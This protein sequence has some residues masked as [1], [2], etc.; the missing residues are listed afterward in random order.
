MEECDLQL[1]RYVSTH[2]GVTLRDA[3]RALGLSS[4]DAQST[5]DRLEHDKLVRVERRRVRTVRIMAEANRYI[6]KFPEEELR[7]SLL[8]KDRKPDDIRNSIALGWAVKNG[9][10]IVSEGLAKITQAG[11]ESVDRPYKVRELLI[12]L[13]DAQSDEQDRLV[14]SEADAAET[15]VKRKL[16]AVEEGS[17]VDGIAVTREGEA[18]LGSKTAKDGQEI[19]QLSKELLLSKGWK[20]MRFKSYDVDAPSD[21]LY[22]ARLHPMH[23]FLDRVRRIW[24]DMGF[25]EVDGPIIE[26]S[27]WNFDALFS[28]QDHPTREMQDTF[29]LAE[30]KTLGIEDEE[31]MA[32]VRA[33]HEKGWKGVWE[34]SI[35]RQALLRTQTTSVSARHIR[36]Y[37][38][39]DGDDPLK[40]ISIGRVFRNES[41]DYKHLAEFYHADGIIIG[42]RLS[43]ANLIHT[44]REFYAQLGMKVRMKPSYFPF[45]EPGMEV[46]YYNEEHGDWIE[47]CGSGVIRKEITNA[48]GNRNTVLAWGAG[49]D[50]LMLDKPGIDSLPELYRNDVDWLKTRK[51]LGGR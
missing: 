25:I 32:R 7:D 13:K 49:L 39:Y 45:V 29:Y 43:L 22:P 4:R 9:W 11:R 42:K 21:T 14:R 23:E 40:L 36:K 26:S 41:I 31:L 27:F 24:L 16:I 10:A 44:L 15:L 6:D 51:E 38:D 33:M 47:L 8:V 50:R 37:A 19:G 46:T 3:G 1:L 17:I 48:L 30:P 18:A 20:G 28:P 5:L 34:D 35:A 12:K 2:G